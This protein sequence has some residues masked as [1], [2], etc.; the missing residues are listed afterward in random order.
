[1]KLKHFAL[2]S[3]LVAGLVVASTTAFANVLPNLPVAV[4]QGGGALIGDTVYA[5]LGSAGDKVFALNLKDPS[6]GWTEI[7]QFPGGGRSQPVVAQ[8]NGKLYVF[9]GLQT[10]NGVL[11]S[12]NDAYEY[13][14]TANKW[15]QLPT[16]SP[17][18]LVGATGFTYGSKIY[19][20][21]GTNFEIFNGYFKDYTAAETKEAKDTVAAKYFD[22]RTQDYFFNDHLFSYEPST[23][24]WR[25][26]GYVDFDGR[27]GAGVAVKGNTFYVVNGEVKP[28]LRTDKVEKGEFKSNGKVDWDDAKDLPA[29]PGDKVQE[30]QAGPYTGLIGGKYV[31][32][33]GGANFPGAQAAYKSGKLF[34]HQGLTKTY[35]KTSFVLRDGKWHYA[36]DLPVASGYGVTI[37]YGDKLILIGGETTK[38]EALSAVW[39][40]TFDP[41]TNKVTFK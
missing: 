18:G 39:E 1:M 9:G 36:G 20:V 17:L 10:V 8:V 28:G 13:D 7:A 14:P 33:A 23:N 21:G 12:V 26:E 41:A 3:T 6:K 34:A 37:T 38:G 32:T 15:T 27:A 25:N 29:N 40:V 11:T 31:F 30:G 5:G 35:Y 24:K 16:R 22:L 19:V 2:K 4:K